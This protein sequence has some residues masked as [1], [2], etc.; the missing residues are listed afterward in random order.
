MVNMK[1]LQKFITQSYSSIRYKSKRR[2]EPMPDITKKELEKWLIDNGIK[3]KW[4][5]Y[6]ESGFDK[7]IRPSIDRI[8]DYGVY[9]FSNMQLITWRENHIKGVN[10]KKHHRNSQNQNLTKPVFIW[11]KSGEFIKECKNHKEAADYLGCHKVSISRA[12]T[13]NRKT[14]KKHIL[15]KTYIFL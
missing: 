7:N 8:N 2:G 11:S 14:V 5:E 13:G 1:T 15:T 10:G 6:I 9:E 12:V 4:I 3:D